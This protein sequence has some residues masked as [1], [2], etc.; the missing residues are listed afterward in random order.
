MKVIVPSF[1]SGRYQVAA[2]NARKISQL[3]MSVNGFESTS[4]PSSTYKADAFLHKFEIWKQALVGNNEEIFV[5]LDADASFT[6]SFSSEILERDLGQ[7]SIGMVEQPQILGSNPRS[8]R[9]LY[10]H[11]LKV[12]HAAVSPLSQKPNFQSFRFFNTGFVVFRR[13][14]LE[15]FLSWVEEKIPSVPREIDGRMVADQD[16]MQVYANEVAPDEVMQLDWS[17]NHCEWWDESFPNPHA[18]VIHMSNFCNGPLASQMNRRAVLCRA[19][20]GRSFGNL[21]VVLVIH[22]SSA[23]INECLGA[24][25]EIPDLQILLV[26]NASTE[27]LDLPKSE[28]I[29]LIRNT[30]NLGFSKAVNLGIDEVCTRYIC[31]LNPDAFLTYEAA[32]EAI[33]QLELDANQL[34]APDFYDASGNLTQ[35]LR[36]GQPLHQLIKD[37]I[38]ESHKL[39][40]KMLLTLIPDRFG[41]DFKWLIGACVFSTKDFLLGIGGLDESYFLYME[42]VELG[43]AASAKGKVSSIDS[44]IEHLGSMSTDRAPNF[45]SQE[46]AGARLKFL[47]RHFGIYPWLFTLLVSGY[48]F[49]T[50]IKRG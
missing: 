44:A 30:K 33:I 11:Y 14:A 8:R 32:E 27:A 4:M 3:Q 43:K 26:D 36:N 39:R 19:T 47:R 38:P 37:I 31:L 41:E 23:V 28:R 17:W 7:R 21:T 1:G 9:D 13:R 16:L 29:R 50:K 24:L 45:K 6:G 10:E 34:L 48:L 46:L 49:R 25:L 12:A 42:D 18:K 20:Q 22:N 2:M 35:A 40:R 5:H 15:N